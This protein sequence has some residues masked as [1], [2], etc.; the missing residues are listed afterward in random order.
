MLIVTN[1]QYQSPITIQINLRLNFFFAIC[2]ISTSSKESVQ[3]ADV[4]NDVNIREGT[5]PHGD[6][7]HY[8]H[9]E[10]KFIK[11]FKYSS[12]YITV[13]KSFTDTEMHIGN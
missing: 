5:S 7:S 10:K 9:S 2:P 4:L 6:S 11:L 13:V 1:I 12:L 3:F 8:D